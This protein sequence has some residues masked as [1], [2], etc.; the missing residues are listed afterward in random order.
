VPGPG[1]L[2]VALAAKPIA[3]K[4]PLAALLVATEATDI[5]D[6]LLTLARVKNAG[7]L[8][9]SLA[10]NVVMSLAGGLLGARLCRDARAGAVIGLVALSHWGLDFIVW[11]DVL[12]LLY[13]GSPKV[14]LGLYGAPAGT[15]EIKLSPQL[16][17]MELGLPAIGLLVHLCTRNRSL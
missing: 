1:H 12:P 4:A 10:T 15:H 14:G 17:A 5:L 3:P 11:K 2:G 6:L 13:E 16:V 8:S 9:H 7:D